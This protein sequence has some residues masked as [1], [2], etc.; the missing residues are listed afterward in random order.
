MRRRRQARAR[1]N[2]RLVFAGMVGLVFV[3]FVVAIVYA[4]SPA[5][6]AK[7]LK[8]DGTDVGGMSGT[9]AEHT[10][11][12]EEQAA[13]KKPVELVAA[14]HDFHVR[15]SQLALHTDWA[16]AVA[17]AR[18]RGDGFAPLRGFRRMMLRLFGGDV[19]STP[20]YDQAKLKALL[21]GIGSVVDD[22]HQ[23]AS[24]VR[25]GLHIA[26]VPAKSGRIL[27]RTA[28]GAAIVS[29]LGSFTRGTP[30]EL[31]TKADVPTVTATTLAPALAQARATVSAPVVLT[32]GPTHLRIPRWKL[33][34]IIELPA[35]GATKL[36][37]GGAGADAFFKNL[38]KQVDTPAHDAQFV[39]TTHGI[40]IQPS[41]D[42][43][44]LDVPATA[45]A[46][47]AAATSHVSR[48]AKIVVATQPPKRTTK[49]LQ[50]MGITELASS[51]TTEFGGVPNR[52]H[53][54]QLVAH[55][56]DNTLIAPNEEFSFN[57]TTGDR[58][59]AKGFLEAPV[60]INGELSNGL[61]GGVCQV[62]TTVFNSA[63]EL[64]LPITARTNHALY[65]SHYPQGRD[66]TVNYP[67]VD[68][69]FINDTGHW[70]LLR[71]FVSTYS[72]TVN[73][74]GTNPHRKVVSTT[75]PLVTTGP[76]PVQ[77]VNDPM[78]TVGQ[79]VTD[80]QGSPPLSTSVERKVYSA[81]GKLLSDH[82]F[83]SNYVGDKSII[84]VGTKPKPKPKPSKPAPPPSSYLGG[85]AGTAT[86][87]ATTTTTTTP[88]TT[89]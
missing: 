30:V 82:V 81:D 86:T 87:P 51:Y 73:L 26:V 7:G 31:A 11:R 3:L 13:A 36:K 33:A 9:Q 60:I 1:R 58:N 62:S 41:S 53:N 50:A 52:I 34:T 20:V 67:D 79:K 63:Y 18:H 77:Y 89:G 70:L 85:L 12:Q 45:N 14:G 71:T 64:G 42:A 76:V 35:N 65:I 68:L 57:K 5:T 24:L 4:G 56:I 66:A 48:T 83:Y 15:A 27:D 17:S 49:D 44:V 80:H 29:S 40:R 78:L 32:L 55:L 39:V 74:Y 69:K 16:A 59:A 61:G 28:A 6:L 72:L 23:E 38:E 37:V 84:R 54:V 2:R 21:A 25:H 47:L 88:T 46:L 75:A 22:P 10:L 8:V 19:T 43:R